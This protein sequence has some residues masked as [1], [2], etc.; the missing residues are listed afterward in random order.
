VSRVSSQTPTAAF[1]IA[2]ASVPNGD[3]FWHTDARLDEL[4]PVVTIVGRRVVLDAGANADLR[5]LISHK[6]N[7]TICL[8]GA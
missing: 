3:S 4:E 1:V 6:G 5:P 2:A 7:Q 8:G